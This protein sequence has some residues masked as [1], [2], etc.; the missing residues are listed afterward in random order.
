M[1]KQAAAPKAAAPRCSAAA[2]DLAKVK[3]ALAAL[4]DTKTEAVTPK[5]EE[6]AVTPKQAGVT[7]SPERSYIFLSD[8][9]EDN[10]WLQTLL[11]CPHREQA[12]LAPIESGRHRPQSSVGAVGPAR[13]CVPS[14]P[15]KRGRPPGDAAKEEYNDY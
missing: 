3:G 13:E 11:R 8:S 15:L 9:D 7:A 1:G 14:A 5:Q 6:Q 12:P 4:D 10:E 2:D